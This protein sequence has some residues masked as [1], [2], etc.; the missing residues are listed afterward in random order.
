M[1]CGVDEGLAP[2]AAGVDP[3]GASALPMMI[4]T[5]AMP[6]HVYHRLNTGFFVATADAAVGAAWPVAGGAVEIPGAR[7]SVQAFPSQYRCPPG[8]SVSGY[9]PA[10]VVMLPPWA[11][12]RAVAYQ[13]PQ[14]RLWLRVVGLRSRCDPDHSEAHMLR[15]GAKPS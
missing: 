9:Q 5:T 15:D 3:F 8:T 10:G 13:R 12:D 7:F 1:A 6:T 14:L 2:V 4:T 11:S